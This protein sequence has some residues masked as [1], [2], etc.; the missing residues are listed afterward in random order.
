[1]DQTLNLLLAECHVIGYL[2]PRLYVFL[3]IEL[4]ANDHRSRRPK[5]IPLPESAPSGFIACGL[6]LDPAFQLTRSS[7]R[8]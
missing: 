2:H 7:T 3:F 1:L 8:I 6:A 4:L 5:I